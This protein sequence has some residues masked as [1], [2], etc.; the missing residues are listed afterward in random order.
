MES[1]FDFF[2][3]AK[4]ILSETEARLASLQSRSNELDKQL[5]ELAS[6]VPIIWITGPG[7]VRAKLSLL[8]ELSNE[9][10]ICPYHLDTK[11]YTADILIYT[12]ESTISLEDNQHAI[13][14]ALDKTFEEDVASE[15]FD[16]VGEVRICVCDDERT[17]EWCGENGVEWIKWQD[18]DRVLEALQSTAWPNMVVKKDVQNRVKA[19]AP[20]TLSGPLPI[21]QKVEPSPEEQLE[22]FERMMAHARE[23]QK[24]ASSLSDTERRARAAQAAEEMARLLG[25][26]D[27]SDND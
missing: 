22:A 21:K 3:R 25:M 7:R 1:V 19:E 13:I 14:L 15:I 2:G 10:S 18:L 24:S 23:I 16:S 4:N 20:K 6:D 8:P 27:D 26:D 12:N 5:L 9:D 11:Y 17:G